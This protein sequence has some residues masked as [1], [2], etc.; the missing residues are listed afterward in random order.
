MEAHEIEEFLRDKYYT[1]EWLTPSQLRRGHIYLNKNGHVM[2]YLGI[3]SYGMHVFYTMAS[4]Y[5]QYFYDENF[6]TRVKIMN[7]DLQVAAISDIIEKSMTRRGD[8]NLI[9]VQKA[10]PNI[11][12][13]FPCKDYEAVYCSWYRDSFGDEIGSKDVPSIDTKNVGSAY[14][15]VKNLRPGE[16]YYTGNG[17]GSIFVFMGRSTGNK[18]I[19]YN[20]HSKEVY[21]NA[22]V[23]DMLMSSRYT[24][25][26][27][28][29]K[30]LHR[31]LEDPSAYDT[32]IPKIIME[33]RPRVD[34]TNVNQHML[35]EVAGE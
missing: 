5:V 2:I 27:K 33:I 12:G 17:W 25:T 6:S 22:T 9:R 13:E 11:F 19:W 3:S 24:T 34:M 29:V 1:E 30:E 21:F 8:K 15:S 16:L 4:C 23:S 26:N 31:I 32:A 7:Q 20:I 28:R 35:D 10:I 14:V 18:F